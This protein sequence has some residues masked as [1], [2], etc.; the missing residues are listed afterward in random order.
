[1]NRA[2]RRAAARGRCRNHTSVHA[3]RVPPSHVALTMDFEGR[4]PSTVAIEAAKLADMVTGIGKVLPPHWAY[5]D[6]AQALNAIHEQCRVKGDAGASGLLLAFWVALNH[7]TGGADMRRAVSDRMAAGKPAH[8]TLHAARG[9]GICLALADRFVDLADPLRLATAA[10][11][12]RVI[13]AVGGG[14]RRGTAQ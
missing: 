14:M 11:I 9:A 3:Y 13:F 7:P 10:G 1:M 8:I 12:G 6:A 2:Q 4:P 5:D